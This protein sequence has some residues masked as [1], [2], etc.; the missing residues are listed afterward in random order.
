M[1]KKFLTTL[2]QGVIGGLTF[3]I[4]HAYVTERMME[5]H[6][7]KLRRQWEDNELKN[8]KKRKWG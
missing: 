4:Y 2:A 5:E 8:M 3:G 6:N 7:A 1:D